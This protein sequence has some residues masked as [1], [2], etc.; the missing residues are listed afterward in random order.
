ME[1]HLRQTYFF[2]IYEDQD[3]RGNRILFTKNLVPGKKVY[4]E[5]LIKEKE[6]DETGK[7]KTVE[8]RT[9]NP[10]RSKLAAGIMKGMQQ[11]GIKPGSFVLY[12]G[13]ASGTTVSHVSDIVGNEG[14]VFA[15]DFAPRVVR[16]LYFV[17][18]DRKNIAPILG[19]ACLPDTYQQCCSSVDVVFQDIAQKSQA[20]IFINNCKKY[21]IKGG[22]GVL[23]VKAR[24]VDVT[25]NPKAI[26]NEIR[27]KLEKE[28]TV[29]DYRELAPFELDHALFVCKKK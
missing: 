29:V 2:G 19:D 27:Q 14:F 10:S 8:Y 1:L 6:K 28:M 13:A 18:K 3:R 24:S 22:F 20:E 9:W 21:L 15:L 17:A 5:D 23:S 4:D 12:L 25:R 16:D 26:F 7:E 11:T